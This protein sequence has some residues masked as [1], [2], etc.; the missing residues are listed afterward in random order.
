LQG[1]LIIGFAICCL[2]QSYQLAVEASLAFL[3]ALSILIP[4]LI[5]EI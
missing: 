4:I 3:A 5:V 1:L 2:Q